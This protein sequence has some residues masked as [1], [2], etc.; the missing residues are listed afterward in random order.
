MAGFDAKSL[1]TWFSKHAR[2]LPW[3]E[4]YR[5]YEVVLSEFM[6]Q[7]TQVVTALPYYNRWVKRWPNWTS[8]AA[9]SEHD[10]LNMWAGLGYYQRARRLLSL[11]Q[12]LV[13]NNIEELPDDAETLMS[14]PGLGPYTSAAV[15]AI[16]FNKV[17]LPIDGNVRRVLSRY[18]KNSEMS[19]SKSQ[20]EFF[21]NQ[22]M[23]V[24]NRIQKRRDL[25]QAL[26]ELGASHCSPRKPDCEN[27]PLQKSC[28]MSDPQEAL[29]YPTKKER[30]KSEALFVSY[31]WVEKNGHWLL[32]QRPDKGR[33][34]RQWEPPQVEASTEQLSF[35]LLQQALPQLNLKL[36]SKQRRD[37]T[38]YKVMWCAFN[39]KV[40]VNFKLEGYQFF[41][42]KSVLNLN[43]V[44]VMA[45]Q[46]KQGV[47]PEDNA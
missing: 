23:P 33:F 31:A 18:Y 8:L 12:H 6:L 15:A 41:D 19:P 34:P 39:V 42:R 1:L 38:R 47:N 35:E 22:L 29:Q 21:E 36:V 10:I 2:P 27:C 25:A 11:A 32:R 4:H 30:R 40:K 3:R 13:S 24:M 43:L 7:Q 9:A 17:A 5:P 14:Y 45:M 20:D 28:A 44:P 16:A 37:F 46:F 26:M